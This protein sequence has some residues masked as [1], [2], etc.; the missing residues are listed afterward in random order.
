MV[1]FVKW[2]RLNFFLIN[3]YCV[4]LYMNTLLERKYY[5]FLMVKNGFVVSKDG[6]LLFM[7]PQQ[8]IPRISHFG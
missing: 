3:I 2:H 8:C 7:K 6:E 5:L 1:N 4:Q